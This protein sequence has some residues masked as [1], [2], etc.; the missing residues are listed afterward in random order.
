[1]SWIV[2]VTERRNETLTS[3]PSLDYQSPRHDE[4]GARLL[5]ELISGVT[6]PQGPGPWRHAIAGGQ[7]TIELR[8]ETA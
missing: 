3:A 4:D 7:R 8:S 5:I 1:M 6:A 2:I